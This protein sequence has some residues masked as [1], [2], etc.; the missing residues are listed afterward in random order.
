MSLVLEKRAEAAEYAIK[1]GDTLEKIAKEQCPD[2]GWK[3]LARY[4]WGIDKPKELLRALAETVG[5]DLADATAI[6]MVATPQSVK[7]KPDAELKPKVKIPK[8]WKK[9]ELVLEKTHTV[10][11]SPIKPANA[12]SILE[13]DKWFLPEEEKCAVEYDLHGDG[14]RADKLQF[15]VFGSNYCECT[16]W[17]EGH[18]TYSD[19]AAMIDEPLYSLDLAK[20]AA[21][22]QSYE[23]PGDG[24]KGE[25]TTAKGVLG[26]KTGAA[27]S[28]YLNVAFSPYTAHFRYFKA[29]ADEKAHLVLEAFWPQWEET[30]SEPAVV[31]A[32]DHSNVRW[33]NA[34]DAD[35]GAYEV[36]D[37][38]GQRVYLA[39]LA[40]GKLKKGEQN[41]AWNGSYAGGTFNGKFAPSRLDDSAEPTPLKK[42][43]FKSE[44]YAHKVTTFKRKLKTDSLKVKWE[45]RK[46]GKLA[47]GL[48]QIVDGAGKLVF[49]K[50]LAKAK[51]AEAKHE[52]A[53]DGKYSV[54]IKN[55]DGGDEAIFKDMPYRVQ[56]QAHTPIDTLEGLA[57]AA[58]HTEVRLHVHDEAYRP[59]DPR[60]DAWTAKSTFALAKGPLVPGD[61]PAEGEGTAWYR[62]KLAEAGFYP[63]PVYAGGA[64]SGP[65]QTA[66]REFKRSVP[67][68]GSQAAPNFA[69]MVLDGGADAAEDA[70]AK[71]ALKTL[72]ASDRR[73]SFGDP[74]QVAANANAVD[75]TDEQVDRRL[76]NPAE[77]MIVW[78]DDRQYYTSEAAKDDN[79]DPFLSGSP[80][81]TAFGLADY[82]G[83]MVNGDAKTATDAAAIPRPWIPLKAELRLMGRDDKLELA[84]DAA[85]VALADARKKDRMRRAIGPLRVDWTFDELPFDVS[86][87][88]TGAYLSAESRSRKYVAWALYNNKASHRR[89]DTERDHLYTNCTEAL[90][91]IRP[92]ALAS[93]YEK[94]F[95]S[96]ALSLKP[97][98]ATTVA[99]TESIAT[100]VHDHLK[101]DQVAAN[102]DK[103]KINLFEPLIGTAGAYFRPSTIAGDGYRVRAEVVFDELAGYKFP[104]LA[105]LKARYPVRPQAASA[106]LRV[107]RRCSVRGYLCWGGATGHWPALL[108]GMRNH[109]KGAHVYYVHEGGAAQAYNVTDVFNPATPAHVTRFKAIIKNNETSAWHQDQAKMTLRTADVWPWG[110]RNDLGWPWVS[111]V[112]LTAGQ[113]YDQFLSPRVIQR[114]W[115]EFRQGLL[116]ALLQQVEK[117]GLMRGHF[118]VEFDASPAVFIEQYKCTGTPPPPGPPV[119]PAPLHTY[120]IITKNGTAA[121]LANGPCPAPGC[122]G[123]LQ[124]QNLGVPYASGLP[125]PAVGVALG[126]TWLFTSSD[127]ETWAHEVGHHKHLEHAASGPGATDNLHDSENNPSAAGAANPA[128]RHWDAKCIMS[129][130]SNPNLCFCGRC[131]LRNRGWKVTGLGFPGTDVVEA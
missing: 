99:A 43:L 31:A 92:A 127:A 1:D 119:P 83:G 48:L 40:A 32:L 103:S 52:Y 21:E 57:L 111:P 36:R 29:K 69:R 51:V 128:D 50:P 13:L 116:L 25:L 30:K 129:Y 130:A 97:W 46:T 125:L 15:E 96:E 53:W 110:D 65:Y 60:F 94:G 72:R 77:E 61:P 91:G 26:H 3:V 33:Q 58:M 44:P 42:L 79:N 107:W 85:K 101:A 123:T 67:A 102:A 86:V 68:D 106:R 78:V 12:V 84:Y 108:N 120:W 98:K 89:K 16:A 62:Y 45:V 22:R 6:G 117:R 75:F 122:G 56:L 54:G 35:F 49:Q 59:N 19:P 71:T 63:G 28:R 121:W 88:N 2:L 20:Q 66:M 55:S 8:Q 7:L 18:G 64:A 24:W 41:L 39:V 90:G 87:I 104:N 112:D 124:D 9:G 93:Y 109:Y 131:L 14:E 10:K 73:A 74:A 76:G 27:A 115:R 4:N 34:D 17:S 37:A 23:L 80:A 5:V 47:H 95:G 105:V 114:T 11:V 126:A 113:L 118:F 100:V 82:R 81:R 70:A 38:T